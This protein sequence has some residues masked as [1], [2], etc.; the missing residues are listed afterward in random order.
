MCEA[1]E[2]K[3]DVN[4]T[5]CFET[6]IR[7]PLVKQ[8]YIHSSGSA[9]LDLRLTCTHSHPCTHSRFHSFDVEEGPIAGLLHYRTDTLK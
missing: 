5:L 1:K 6:F 9:A 3:R 4:I 2:A 8:A 7:L